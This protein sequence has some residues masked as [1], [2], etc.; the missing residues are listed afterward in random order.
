MVSSALMDMYFKCSSITNGH[1][2]FD[3]VVNRNVVT[4]TNLISGYG[5]HGRVI[6]VL[7]SFDK[8]KNEGFIPNYITFLAVLSAFEAWLMKVG[9]ISYQ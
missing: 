6:E 5:Q 4:W 3:K 7:E 9:T 8:M 2:V 1:Q